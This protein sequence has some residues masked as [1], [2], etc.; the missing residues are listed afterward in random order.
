MGAVRAARA[1]R[2]VEGAAWGDVGGMD[3]AAVAL[4]C[5][6]VLGEV[7]ISVI[8]RRDLLHA[9]SMLDAANSQSHVLARDADF[10]AK[11][12]KRSRRI[13]YSRV[14]LQALCSR[15]ACLSR[16][17]Q[18]RSKWAL[19][20]TQLAVSLLGDSSRRGPLPEAEHLQR[21]AGDELF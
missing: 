14:C 18:W 6:A 19:C 7:G 11:H 2:A 15:V 4:C 17:M 3:I 13:G 21:Y 12:T 10:P 20:R 8:P 1:V 5:M 9:K 16:A